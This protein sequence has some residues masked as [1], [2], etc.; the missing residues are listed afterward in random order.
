MNAGSYLLD[1][2][3]K[4][5]PKPFPSHIWR[6][7]RWWIG[8]LNRRQACRDNRLAWADGV[9]VFAYRGALLLDDVNIVRTIA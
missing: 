4:E 3:A 6:V 9:L 2:A 5:R 7:W 8:K 1:S